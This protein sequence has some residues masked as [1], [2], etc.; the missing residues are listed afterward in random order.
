MRL[1]GLID[2]YVNDV[3]ARLPRRARNQAAAELRRQITEL[4]EDAAAEA[5]CVPDR[6][7]VMEVLRS[8]GRP[9]SLAAAYRRGGFHLIR[10]DGEPFAARGASI[11]FPLVVVAAILIIAPSGF[12]ELA[13]RDAIRMLT[14]LCGD[15]F[16]H[17]TF[18]PLALLLK[19]WLLIFFV[20]NAIQ[21]AVRT[22]HAGL[23]YAGAYLR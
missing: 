5:G 16:Q 10:P 18:V 3:A 20:V 19:S 13:V 11:L 8:V 9:A 22:T 21:L 15:G 4:L 23:A 1:Q 14:D 2:S 17:W 6:A 7:M 12:F